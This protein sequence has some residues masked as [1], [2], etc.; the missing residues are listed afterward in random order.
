[1]KN[2]NFWE[3]WKNKSKIEYQVIKP[4]I[5]ARELVVKSIPR[6]KLIAIYIKGSFARREM[7]ENSDVDIV[8]IVRDNQDEAPVFNVNSAKIRPCVVVPLSIWELKNNKLFTK[9]SFKPDLRAR[10][11]VF[12]RDLKFYKLIYGDG[13]NI[14]KFK[15]RTDLKILKEDIHLLLNGYIPAYKRRRIKFEDLLKKVFWLVELEQK[16]NGIKADHSFDGINGAVKDKAHIIH[17]CFKLR[18]KRKILLSDKR[19]F[20]INLG[21]Y[22]KTLDR[23]FS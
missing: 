17:L 10:P 14:K 15:I 6:D 12:L 8:P 21:D 11:D 9:S 20:L 18:S 5:K 19:E 1:M 4:V 2:Y 16:L 3:N 23:D 13:L 22:L 7:K